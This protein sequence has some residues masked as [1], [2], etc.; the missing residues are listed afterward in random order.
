MPFPSSLVDLETEWIS[1][2]TC[3]FQRR[4]GSFLSSQFPW[5]GLAGGDKDDEW[6][7]KIFQE[8][9]DPLPLAIMGHPQGTL[10]SLLVFLLVLL[11]SS[12]FE[13]F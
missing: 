6:P 12:C 4:S 8:G 1:F 7:D 13:M 5:Q 3:S 9:Q 10:L 2:G 11:A